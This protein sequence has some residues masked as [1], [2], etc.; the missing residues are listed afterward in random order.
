MTVPYD[1]VAELNNPKLTAPILPEGL[2]EGP[3]LS[4]NAFEKYELRRYVQA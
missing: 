2:V 3:G 4:Y 1:M